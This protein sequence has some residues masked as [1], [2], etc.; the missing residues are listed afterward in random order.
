VVVAAVTEIK[1]EQVVLAAQVVVVMEH[2][3]LQEIHR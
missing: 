3:E 2:M 1:V